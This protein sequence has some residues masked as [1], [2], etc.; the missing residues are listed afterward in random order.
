MKAPPARP[1]RPEWGALEL[2][3]DFQLQPE[4]ALDLEGRR[5]V[6][7][8]DASVSCDPPYAFSRLAPQAEVGYTTHAMNPAALLAVFRQ[9]TGRAP[10]PAWLLTLRGLSFELGAP[11]S[12][13]AQSHLE[14]A[15]D[16]VASLL[17]GEW[18]RFD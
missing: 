2:L 9:I 4:H 16:F 15:A 10:P 3:T 12:P 1:S 11:L 6:L 5:R 8:I 13:E 14:A 18:Q 17:A 7:F